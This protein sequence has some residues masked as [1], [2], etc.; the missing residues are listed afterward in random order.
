MS[1]QDKLPHYWICD[2]CA[3]KKGGKIPPGSCGTMCGG[4]CKYC[5]DKNA[6]LTPIVDF[7]WPGGSDPVWD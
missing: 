3:K 5:G 6:V 2:E 1:K 4:E 7:K